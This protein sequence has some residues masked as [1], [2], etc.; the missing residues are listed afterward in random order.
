MIRNLYSTNTP[1]EPE[2]D[3]LGSDD[4]PFPG[5]PYFQVPAVNLPGCKN[6]ILMVLSQSPLELGSSLHPWQKTANNQGLRSLSNKCKV[7]LQGG[8]VDLTG[9]LFFSSQLRLANWAR[10]GPPQGSDPKMGRKKQKNTTFDDMEGLQW[11]V[12][13]IDSLEENSMESLEHTWRLRKPFDVSRWS[14]QFGGIE[15]VLSFST[16]HYLGFLYRSL[17]GPHQPSRSYILLLI[18]WNPTWKPVEVNSLSRYLQGFRNIQTV[19][20][21]WDFSHQQ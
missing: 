12:V 5:G 8:I 10:Y 9:N 11:V 1:I 19:G 21:E 20:W 6:G 18:G 4:F 16:S 7:N 3:G 2:N 17:L 15:F 13:S 14:L